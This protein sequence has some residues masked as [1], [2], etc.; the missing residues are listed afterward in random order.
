MRFLSPVF[1][2]LPFAAH[3][4]I[5]VTFFE[6]APK[7]RFVLVNQG[8]ELADYSLQ[9]N[10]ATAPSG[11]IF[12][13]TDAGAG[14]E[15]F[16]PVEVVAGSVNMSAVT[17]GDQA[18]NLEIRTFAINE[19]IVISADLDD[20]QA[21]GALGQIRVAGS[22]I[23]GAT[24]MGSDGGLGIFDDTASARLATPSCIS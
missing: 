1:L 14:V 19:T 6:G 4:D 24:L 10:L 20:T 22:E 9:I 2:L 17:D 8:C 15:V 21:D 7:D 12:D 23:A 16:Q 5:V 18:V 11:L 3:A 13:V